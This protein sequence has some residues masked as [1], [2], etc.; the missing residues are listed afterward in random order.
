MSKCLFLYRHPSRLLYIILII[1]IWP[2]KSKMA[3]KN[4]KTNI[5]GLIINLQSRVI[6]QNVCFL[7]RYPICLR[8]I[9][10]IISIWPPKSKMATKNR[11]TNITGLIIN[12][13]S[14]VICQNV[15]FVYR[16]LIRLLYIISII[17]VWPPKSKMAAKNVNKHKWVTKSCN[18]YAK[19]FVS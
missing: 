19:T 2:P 7:Y 11:K 16:Y 1:S 5:T 9:I 4:R 15:C 18:T 10:S 3:T 13:Q 6:C 14:R 12:L 8:Y 17:S